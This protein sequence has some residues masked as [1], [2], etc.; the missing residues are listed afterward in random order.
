MC[1]SPSSSL[2]R[3]CFP[4]LSIART[5][6]S[7]ALIHIRY[8]V[9]SPSITV[10]GKPSAALASKIEADEKLRLKAQRK[11][12]GNEGLKKKAEELKLAQTFNEREI[13]K[14]VLESFE[15]PSVSSD[16]TRLRR[17]F[18]SRLLALTRRALDLT[19]GRQRFLD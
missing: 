12:L 7:L 5:D 8:F 1:H 3:V 10:V 6:V 2:R 14:E 4:F 9:S 13:P 17:P 19:A 15:V 11:E 16:P 18:S